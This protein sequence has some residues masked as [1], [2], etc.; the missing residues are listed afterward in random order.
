MTRFPL[1]GRAVAAALLLAGAPRLGAQ[2]AGPSDRVAALVAA[3][4]SM[5]RRDLWPG[6]RPDTI[7]LAI[8]DGTRTVLVRH[9]APPPEFSR[10]TRGQ[11]VAEMNGRHP[12][13]TAN[14]SADVGGRRT[15]T[16][17]PRFE[18]SS[19]RDWAAV[20]VHEAFHVYQRARHASW[21]ANEADLFTYPFHDA[22]ALARRR[23]ELA[24][25]RRALEVE[26]A[27]GAACWARA[28]LAERE[29][30]FAALGAEPAAYERGGELNEGIA[31]YVQ[32][33][34]SGKP[35]AP[36]LTP[37]ELPPER[38]RDRV[39]LTG[40]AIGQIL[41]RLAPAWRKELELADAAASLDG[42]LARAVAARGGARCEFTPA[43]RADAERVAARD[44]EALAS[45][46]ADEKARFDSA[47]GASL[48]V[49]ASR[50]TLSVGGF[51]PLNVV[52]LSPSEIIHRRYLAL[53]NAAG[54]LEVIGHTAVTE[55]VPAAAHPLFSGVR[56]LRLTGLP[57]APAVA[58]R[59]GA[60]EVTA[61]GIRLR[62]RG[63]TVARDGARVR[64]TLASTP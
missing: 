38:V 7:P 43:E 40:P 22:G 56:R 19:P 29:G 48:E 49:D 37:A 50:A 64:V 31:N 10:V 36:E 14:S 30:R 25:L 27:G 6:F 24:A 42:A 35:L 4:D 44:V 34:A 23:L 1:A 45:R 63:A 15:A 3:F 47:A 51:D 62:F 54:E 46:L 60:V 2:G 8:F 33:R 52:R 53:K 58:E 61:E 39:Y 55:G 12:A 5:V 28:A 20:M 41:D 9:P 21:Q 17:L 59:D 18:G 32:F 57:A 11:I 13:V 16:L 26:T